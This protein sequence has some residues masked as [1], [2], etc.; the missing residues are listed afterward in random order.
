MTVDASSNSATKAIC[1]STIVGLRSTLRWVKATQAGAAHQRNQG[2]DLT[3]HNVIWFFDDDILFEPDCVVRLWQA[4]QGDPDIGGVNAMIVNQKYQRPGTV[5][6]FLFT[7]MNGKA[8][9]SFA[10]KV[11]GPAINLLP[12]DRDDLPSIVP[13]E[14]LNTTCTMYRRVALPSPVFDTFFTDYSL[15]EDLA[16]SLRVSQR[17]WKL[18]NARCARIVH[19]SEGG[20]HKQDVAALAAMELRNRRYLMTEILQRDK[21]TDRARLLLW[22]CFAAA[23]AV[24]SAKGIRSLPRVLS[25]KL[26]ALRSI[27]QPGEGR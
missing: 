25:G 2:I 3:E 20:G 26:R 23:S 13:V 16:L 17:G 21:L 18:A 6:R 10:G 11:I 27:P 9:Q 4:L 7:L 1:Q 12:E 5:S 15:M 14:W 19:A 24:T 22:E 8:E